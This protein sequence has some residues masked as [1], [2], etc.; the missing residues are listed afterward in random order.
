MRRK[1]L[2]SSSFN[3]LTRFFF[4]FGL[5]LAIVFLFHFLWPVHLFQ[6]KPPHKKLTAV[7]LKQKNAWQLNG[8]RWVDEVE[9]K[10]KI[11][12]RSYNSN[13]ID[14][15]NCTRRR[16]RWL[17][18]RHVRQK[19]V[20]FLGSVSLSLCVWM[21]WWFQFNTIIETRLNT[22]TNKQTHIGIAKWWCYWPE[23][24]PAT[25][26]AVQPHQSGAV[27]SIKHR[28]TQSKS[29]NYD[30]WTRQRGEYARIN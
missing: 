24:V 18:L 23:W 29:N 20:L 14:C 26:L 22:H 17:S 1:A 11:K 8:L 30:E 28:S 7:Q 10:Q 27:K 3:L 16:R 6:T 2:S 12:R 13:E 15:L 9:T 19:K 25:A 21:K 5:F 4:L